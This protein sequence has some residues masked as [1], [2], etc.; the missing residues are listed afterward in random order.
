MQKLKQRLSQVPILAFPDFT[1]T[2]ILDMDA[3]N[4]GIGEVLSQEDDGRGT[5]GTYAS[6]LLSKAKGDTVSQR[7]SCWLL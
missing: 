1:K 6:W 3:S 5:V 4:D 7:E 2:F